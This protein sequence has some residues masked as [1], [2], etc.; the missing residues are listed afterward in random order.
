MTG[1][2]GI[3]TRQRAEGLARGI[4]WGITAR[5]IT[6]AEMLLTSGF[7]KCGCPGFFPVLAFFLL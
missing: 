1:R 7:A 6:L 2:Y 5:E 3:R 4:G